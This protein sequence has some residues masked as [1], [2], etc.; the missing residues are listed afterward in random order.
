MSDQF[1]F[2]GLLLAGSSGDSFP[3]FY[4]DRV[5]LSPGARLTTA[6]LREAYAAWAGERG[7]ALGSLRAMRAFMEANGHPQSKSSVMYYRDAVLGDFEGKPMPAR[8]LPIVDARPVREAISVMADDLDQMIG[9]L[10]AM[11]RRLA[12]IMPATKRGGA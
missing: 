2:E 3:D 9:D 1:R 6:D 7:A 10:Q 5:R 4:R 8:S 11:R 12:R